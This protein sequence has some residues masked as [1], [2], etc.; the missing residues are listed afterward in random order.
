MNT[1]ELIEKGEGQYIEFKRNTK[2]IGKDIAA[3]ANTN[4]GTVLVGV[5][6]SGSILYR[7]A[8]IRQKR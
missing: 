7:S 3:F 6:D 1:N 5:D 2:N 4:D 8:N